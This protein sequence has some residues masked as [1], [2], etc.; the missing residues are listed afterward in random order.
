MRTFDIDFESFRVQNGGCIAEAFLPLRDQGLV[1][2]KGVN[3]DR[4][5]G[6]NGSGKTTLF[7]LLSTALCGSGG[8]SVTKNGYLPLTGGGNMAMNLRF[9]TR[10][11]EYESNYYR[12]HKVEGTRVE[13]WENGVDITPQT[14]IDDVQRLV[15]KKSGLTEKEWFGSVYLTQTHAHALVGGTP[16]ER[17]DY[18][19]T[20]FGLDAIDACVRVNTKWIAGIQLPDED[21][22]RELLKTCEDALS[23]IPEASVL[24][25]Q[26][27]ALRDRAAAVN[28][29]LVNAGIEIAG[30]ERARGVENER[31]ERIRRLAEV[32][33]TLSDAN[34]S[35]IDALRARLD[36][37][38]S[39]TVGMSTRAKTQAQLDSLPA[40][41]MDA[42]TANAEARRLQTHVAMLTET[43]RKLGERARL[44]AEAGRILAPDAEPAALKSQ[45]QSLQAEI[46]MFSAKYQVFSAEIQKLVT[47]AGKCPMCMRGITDE[48][49]DGLI[50]QRKDYL[51]QYDDILPGMKL[52]YT[53]LE[54]GLRAVEAKSRVLA[55]LSGL[56]EGDVASVTAESASASARIQELT[57]AASVAMRRAVLEGQLHGVHVNEADILTAEEVATI[58]AQVPVLRDAYEFVVRHS[59]VRFSEEALALATAARDDAA[60]E[61][62]AVNEAIAE[63][64]AKARERTQLLA[65]QADI[66]DKLK[67]HSHEKQ[68][69]RVLETLQV[70]LKDTRAKSLRECTEMLRSALPMYVEQLFPGDGVGVELAEDDDSIDFFLKDSNIQIPMKLLSGGE[71][72][73]VGL[74]ILFAFA[75]LGAKSA[76]ILI[77]DEP[78]KDL[79][80][81]GRQC[82]YE[83]LRD[84]GIPSIFVT[85]HDQDQTHAGMYDRVFTMERRNR[86]SRL[87]TD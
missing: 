71:A 67:R 74:A 52:K 30:H 51:K 46:S 8:K 45:M 18:L 56:P 75:K 78:Y 10:T 79:D 12:K 14:D 38:N 58:T 55:A 34:P 15:L 61:S 62:A 50:N 20:H 65:Q 40:V 1:Q 33:Y 77:A 63:A 23:V 60:R 6:S 24:D 81:R 83:L 3:H 16:K 22:L 86:V 37:H 32:G 49:R 53:E 7:D 72:K 4:G 84:L 19:A 21:A 80:P 11:G 64:S 26:L 27:R 57:A 42:D 35:A 2:V 17:K 36:K 87:I 68:R 25:E 9:R 85:S 59:D 29:V 44:E 47:L 66:N 41:T 31:R 82:T 43:L 73:R 39:A 76:N 48:E 5:G 54:A 28:K 70:V 69:K 13:L